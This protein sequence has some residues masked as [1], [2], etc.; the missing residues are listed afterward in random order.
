MTLNVEE[1]REHLRLRRSEATG[2][3]TRTVSPKERDAAVTVV[4]DWLQRHHVREFRFPDAVAELA[5]D[6]DLA[7]SALGELMHAGLLWKN[8][9]MYCFAAAQGRHT[10]W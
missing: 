7:R 9:G 1:A 3:G 2:I 5:G 6:A 10:Q 4:L 8:R